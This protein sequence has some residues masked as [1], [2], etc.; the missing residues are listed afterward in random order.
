MEFVLR[1]KTSFRRRRKTGS[2]CAEWI[3]RNSID[4]LA[5]G[6]LRDLLTERGKI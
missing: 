4:G 2:G 6:M 5:S 3:F 1:G